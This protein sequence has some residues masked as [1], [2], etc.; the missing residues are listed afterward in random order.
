MFFTN[1]YSFKVSVY[2]LRQ[3]DGINGVKINREIC[4]L[5]VPI[6]YL[7]LFLWTET[8]W[9]P[10]GWISHLSFVYVVQ[11]WNI[12]RTYL[13]STGQT[14]AICNINILKFEC[15][16]RHGILCQCLKWCFKKPKCCLCLEKET[17]DQI[18]SMQ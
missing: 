14:N 18:Y 4:T 1:V 15:N 11:E 17:N 16:K 6:T 13:D 8:L 12:W 2:S 5:S 3:C 10:N 7:F 9:K